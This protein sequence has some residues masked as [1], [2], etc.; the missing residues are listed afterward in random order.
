[1]KIWSD[2]VEKDRHIR[3]QCKERAIKNIKDIK[4]VKDIVKYPE[5][6]SD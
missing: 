1:M 6:R 3:Q 4:N 5:Y 2:V